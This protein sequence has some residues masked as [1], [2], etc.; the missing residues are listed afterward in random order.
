MLFRLINAGKVV[1]QVS[2][3]ECRGDW[4]PTIVPTQLLSNGRQAHLG[5]DTNIT[6][7]PPFA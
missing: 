2:G 6:P 3:E 4:V 7:F 5:L 1:Q